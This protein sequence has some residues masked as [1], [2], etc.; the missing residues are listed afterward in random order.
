MGLPVVATAWGGPI[1][2]LDSSCGIVV[3]PDSRESLIAGFSDAMTRLA[4]SSDLRAR[5]GAAGYARARA[6]FDWD[7]KIDQ[8]LVLY[9]Q[10][11]RSRSDIGKDRLT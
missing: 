7:R 1:D 8:I 6:H 4:T 11:I 10:A 9:S 2:Y 5:L 3:K